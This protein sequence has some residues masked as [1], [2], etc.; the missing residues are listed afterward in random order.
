MIKRFF[1]NKILVV[2]L[3][4]LA[5]LLLV[6][7]A[8][9][10]GNLQFQPA[11]PIIR[12]ESNTIQFSVEKIAKEIADIPLWK[13]VFLWALVFILVIIVA[14][15]FSPE[16]R[17]RIIRYFLRFALFVL[18]L[19][20]ILKNFHSLFSALDLG[21]KISAEGNVP[22]GGESA[23]AV[24]TPPQVSSV[25]LYLISLGVVLTLVVGTF[26][27]GR[28]W[29]RKQQLQKVAQPLEDLAEIAHESLT[30]I[31][32]GRDWEDVIIKCYTRM[33]DVVGTRRG[34]HRRQDLTASEFAARLEEAGLPGEAVRRLTRLFEAARYGAKDASREEMLEAIN[35][36]TMVQHACGV[37]E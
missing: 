37:N 36:L 7:L 21:G 12:S 29:L 31:F 9:G 14:S 22:A 20:Y 8:A 17:K 6:L 23:T 27:I 15:L 18:A 25:F 32:S 5:V 34:L 11:R 19:L 24:F 16:M 35:C 13:Q 28:W 26:L 10:L 2:T 3:A 4:C 1:D 30:D 33:S